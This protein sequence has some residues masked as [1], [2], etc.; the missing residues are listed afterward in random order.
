MVVLVALVHCVLATRLSHLVVMPPIV[1][2]RHRAMV[3][4][5]SR[6]LNTQPVVRHEFFLRLKE[7]LFNKKFRHIYF[8]LSQYSSIKII[9]NILLSSHIS[10]LFPYQCARP[11]TLKA[12]VLASRVPEMRLNQHQVTLLTVQ[13]IHRV[14]APLKYQMMTT[15]LAVSKSVLLADVGDG[16]PPL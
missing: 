8:F 1:T 7:D 9:L 15:Q 10:F 2:Q 11:A 14:M 3:S 12:E 5:M 13:L 16:G 6:M 4:P